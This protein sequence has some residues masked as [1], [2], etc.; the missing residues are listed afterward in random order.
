MYIVAILLF[1]ACTTPASPSCSSVPWA[2]VDVA[3]EDSAD[4]EQVAARTVVEHAIAQFGLWSGEAEVCVSSVTVTGG[5]DATVSDGY[6]NGEIGLRSGSE[7][8]WTDTFHA[9]CHA[10]DASLNLTRDNAAL[11]YSQNINCVNRSS[12]ACDFITRIR[13][14]EAFAELCSEGPHDATLW[15]QWEE[16]YGFEW[17]AEATAFVR[18]NV[19]PNADQ[20]PWEEPG[21]DIEFGEPWSIHE[22]LGILDVV[23]SD[24]YLYTLHYDYEF[25]EYRVKIYDPWSGELLRN[26]RPDFCQGDVQG[27]GIDVL[28]G[29]AN[30][31]MIFHDDGGYTL[32]RLT[33]DIVEEVETPCDL[34]NAGVERGGILFSLDAD[35]LS[36]CDIQSGEATSR[37]L[38]TPSTHLFYRDELASPTL[39]LNGDLWWPGVAVMMRPSEGDSWTELPLPSPNRGNVVAPRPGLPWL[40]LIGG[41]TLATLDPQ[42]GDL[43]AP[44]DV[45]T[46]SWDPDEHNSAWLY[47]GDGWALLHESEALGEAPSDM[48]PIRITAR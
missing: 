8:L 18:E 5:E 28:P 43:A 6:Q 13:T 27:C 21:F 23:N 34:S 48:T 39:L 24:A 4:P 3:V 32:W 14:Q 26:Y 12:L 36:E 10:V 37:A 46:F 31:W 30:G 33:P 35:G 2:E 9:L 29:E 42:T 16:C 11:F 40:V 1:H 15:A 25:M 45:C 19:Y 38:P 20:I 41:L 22:G 47:A 44:P 7:H 17:D